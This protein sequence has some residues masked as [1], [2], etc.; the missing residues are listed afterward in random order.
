M[1]ELR[2]ALVNL[3][4]TELLRGF[5]SDIMQRGRITNG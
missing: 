3:Q 5:L 2:G 1:Q 4:V